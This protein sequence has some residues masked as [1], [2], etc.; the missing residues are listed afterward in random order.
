M[1]SS[2]AKD[3]PAVFVRVVSASVMQPPH[4]GKVVSAVDEASLKLIDVQSRGQGGGGGT[5]AFRLFAG[6]EMAANWRGFDFSSE[7]GG[8]TN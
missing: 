4:E 1:A 5:R 7:D 8:A 2:S 6:E 3:I